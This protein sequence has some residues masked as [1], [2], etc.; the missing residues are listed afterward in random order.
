MSPATRARAAAWTLAAALAVLL[1]ST[2]QGAAAQ[3][4]VAD[5][6]HRSDFVMNFVGG[7][8]FRGWVS[9]REEEDTRWVQ[10]LRTLGDLHNQMHEF[11][12]ELAWHHGEEAGGEELVPEVDTRISGGDWTEY[13]RALEQS[14]DAGV[15]APTE[16][17]LRHALVQ[18]V[19]I[20][21][22]RVHHVMFKALARDEALGHGDETLA[23]LVQEGRGYLHEETLPGEGR[24]RTEWASPEEFRELQQ[25]TS[26]SDP[27]LD[28]AFRLMADFDDHLHDL[29][30][31]WARIGAEM[32]EAACQPPEYDGRIS[33]HAWHA[34]HERAADCSDPSWRELVT[35]TALMHDRIRHMMVR[36]AAYI[37]ALH[38]GEVEGP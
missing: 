17:R 19:E 1:V 3:A 28:E 22:D 18:V 31:A 10:S 15:A 37:E 8:D 5:Q 21:H 26:V 34:Y 23:D 32:D 9:A 6:P 4:A 33:G 35:V 36:M 14:P 27:H 2:P 20:M 25:T 24:S 12:T 16:A 11:M 7:D 13:R 30:E 38:P 29:M